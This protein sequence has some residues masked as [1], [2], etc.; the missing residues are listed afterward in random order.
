MNIKSEG[1]VKL[2]W[3][4]SL[5]EQLQEAEEVTG[6]LVVLHDLL[7]CA[8]AEERCVRDAVITSGTHT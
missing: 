4:V 8:A 2:T 1:L 7:T 3:V 6:E 5:T